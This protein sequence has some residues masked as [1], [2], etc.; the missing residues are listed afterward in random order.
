MINSYKHDVY[1]EHVPSIWRK[2]FVGVKPWK[3]KKKTIVFSLSVISKLHVMIN[4]PTLVH[5]SQRTRGKG[6]SL[7]N[8]FVLESKA[9]AK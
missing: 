8:A 7:C 9:T 4:V 2:N 1:T 3:Y 6:I 5:A